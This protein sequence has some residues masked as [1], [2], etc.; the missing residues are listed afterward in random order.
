MS[1]NENASEKH[2]S[3]AAALE[4]A[5]AHHKAAAA[6][7]RDKRNDEAKMHAIAAEKASADAFEKS[8]EALKSELAK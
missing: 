5:A 2:I 7:L 1:G 8:K 4:Q 6:S 3:A